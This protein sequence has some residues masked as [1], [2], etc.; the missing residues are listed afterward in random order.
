MTCALRVNRYSVQRPN[1]NTNQFKTRERDKFH[2]KS[3]FS[4]ANRQPSRQEIL[5]FLWTTEVHCRVHDRPPLDFIL[6]QISSPS[7]RPCH[8][9]KSD[10]ASRGLDAWRDE[11]C[12]NFGI[13]RST[14]RA[15]SNMTRCHVT[16]HPSDQ[17]TL[18]R[19][20]LFPQYKGQI[21]F[22]TMHRYFFLTVFRVMWDFPWAGYQPLTG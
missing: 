22:E 11:V 3:S 14:V 6:G 13:R 20:P 21:Q 10:T 9:T 12:L 5:S 2:T 8:V 16:R 15:Q 4:K 19:T 1:V 7:L 17:A 18:S